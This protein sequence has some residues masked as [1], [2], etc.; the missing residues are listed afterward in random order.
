MLCCSRLY[1]CSFFIPSSL[2]G[3]CQISPGTW[4]PR[5]WPLNLKDKGTVNV[6]DFYWFVHEVFW[7][8]LWCFCFIFCEIDKRQASTTCF[9]WYLLHLVLKFLCGW[10]ID[11]FSGKP[12]LLCLLCLYVTVASMITHLLLRSRLIAKWSAFTR[13]CKVAKRHL[14]NWETF[15]RNQYCMDSDGGCKDRCLWFSPQRS[16]KRTLRVSI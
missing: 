14:I 12:V 9:S 8:N 7:Y 11:V 4:M 15:H 1:P 10:H 13:C 5:A 3:R 6:M 16:Q 2:L